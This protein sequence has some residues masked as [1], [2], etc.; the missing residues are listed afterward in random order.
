MG[1]YKIGA[2]AQ[3]TRFLLIIINVLFLI[4]G[5]TVFICAIVLKW[6]GSTFSDLISNKD[7]NT[8]INGASAISG[9]SVFFLILGGVIILL[10]LL[11]LLGAKY[12]NRFFLVL[13][14]IVIIVL[15]LAQAISI[16]VLVFSS[17]KIEK[18]YTK[19]LNETITDINTHNNDTQIITDKCKIMKSLSELFHCCGSTSPKDF[20]NQTLVTEKICCS[21]YT[22][23]YADGCADKSIKKIKDNVVSFL[24]IPSSIILG[25]EFFA[26]ITVPFL[27]GK[28][29]A[30]KDD[31]D[32]YE[33]R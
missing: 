29:G 14:E 30:K 15:F 2:F 26:M 9:V 3:C 27:V 20:L 6:G 12:M 25:I 31:Y 1:S 28:A 10:S 21:E 32:S 33:Y 24:V 17:S 23:D 7:L 4:L 19:A 11:G 8:L 13:Y 16:L 5:L 18:E 22:G